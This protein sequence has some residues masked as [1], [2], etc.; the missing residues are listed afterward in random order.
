[1]E[2]VEVLK[3]EAER[4]A[5]EYNELLHERARLR[6]QI[7]RTAD[8]IKALNEFLANEGGEPIEFNLE[9]EL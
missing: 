9:G 7:G 6:M 8:Y 2:F 3:A 5:I 4:K 1:M